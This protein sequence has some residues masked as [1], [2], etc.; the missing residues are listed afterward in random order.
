LSIE[1]GKAEFQ[2]IVKRL[3]PKVKVYIGQPNQG[4]YNVMLDLGGRT[5]SVA[6]NE[7]EFFD[8]VGEGGI[9]I[10]ANVT[11]KIKGAIDRIGGSGPPR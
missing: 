9:S 10:R 1:R 7:D 2:A 11:M 4:R 6:M 8:L 5:S 3:S